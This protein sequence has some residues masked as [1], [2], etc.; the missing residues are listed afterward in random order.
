LFYWG[1]WISWSPFVGMFIARI[2]RG[3]TI[4]EFIVGV[5]LVPSGFI[6]LWFT[7]FGNTALAMQLDGTADMVDA[8]QQD[9]AVALFQFLEHLPFSTFSIGLATILVMIFF[10]TSSD[11]ASLVIDM[12]TSGGAAEPPVWQRIFWALMEGVV[13][14]VL[15][16]SEEHTS[17]LQSRENLVCR[18]LLE[19]KKTKKC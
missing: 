1:W 16:R 14:A 17:E 13:A 19:K 6:F 5:L 11:S 7:I 2:S 4:R 9:V 10:V 8:V 12:I 15:L 3:R 18:L